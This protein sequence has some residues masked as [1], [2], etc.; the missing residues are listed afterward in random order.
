M[1]RFAKAQR[2]V[3]RCRGP[4]RGAGEAG[5]NGR[6]P[7]DGA[8]ARVLVVPTVAPPQHEFALLGQVETAV[9]YQS[10]STPWLHFGFGTC[11]HYT[12]LRVLW[13]SGRVEELGPGAAGRR[14]VIEEGRGIVAEERLP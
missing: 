13:P 2:L 6:T 11:E 5:P 10:A 12:S 3:V 1:N 8:G 14:L 9:G 7:A 4:K